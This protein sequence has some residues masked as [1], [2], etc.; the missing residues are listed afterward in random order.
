MRST[1]PLQLVFW[2]LIQ[3]QLDHHEKQQISFQELF[4]IEIVSKFAQ[5]ESS[6]LFLVMRQENGNIKIVEWIKIKEFSPKFVQ[7]V[8]FGNLIL[9]SEFF[10]R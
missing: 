3:N 8:I 9:L 4:G 5:D 6:S 2:D 7:N 1:N 10:G